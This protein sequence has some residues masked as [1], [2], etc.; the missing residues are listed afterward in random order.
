MDWTLYSLVLPIQRSIA[1]LPALMQ[2]CEERGIIVLNNFKVKP[3]HT[4]HYA[5]L[6]VL[7]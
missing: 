1:E 7:L 3:R 5:A 2:T 4:F 6:V